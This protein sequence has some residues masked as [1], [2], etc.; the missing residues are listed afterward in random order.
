MR[1][2]E[3]EG[4]VT[5]RGGEWNGKAF[6][7]RGRLRILAERTRPEGTDQADVTIISRNYSD[8]RFFRKEQ[9]NTRA[10]FPQ[11]KIRSSADTTV[12]QKLSKAFENKKSIKN[13]HEISQHKSL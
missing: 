2:K 8:S 6:K 10:D 3:G 1:I 12:S 7:E 13:S 4:N 9:I 5:G 11:P